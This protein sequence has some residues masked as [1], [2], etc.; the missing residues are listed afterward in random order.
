[1][2][3]SHSILTLAL[4]ASSAYAR[5]LT[6]AEKLSDLHQLVAI[7]KSG[8]GPLEYKKE[9]IGLDVDQLSAKYSSIVQDTRSNADF[10]RSLI[11]FVAEFQ[12]SHFSSW[13]PTPV[14][15]T[16]PFTT[17]LVAGKVVIDT[18][19]R[20]KLSESTFPFQRG[21]EIVSMNGQSAADL[22]TE[23]SAYIGMGFQGS[24][25]RR[26]AMS[27][28]IRPGK[29]FPIP[30]GAVALIIRRG[31]S[32]VT[33]PAA[34]TWEIQGEDAEPLATTSSLREFG[35]TVRPAVRDF[36]RIS[37]DFLW[38]DYEKYRTERSFRCSGDSRIT[39]PEGAVYIMKT[40]F[41]AYYYPTPKGN[42]GYLRIP[43]YYPEN[44]NTGEPEFEL[45]FKQYEYAVAELERN[46]VGLIIDQ[47][48]NCGGSVDYL[49]QIASLFMGPYEPMQFRLLANKREF[50]AFQDWVNNA[51][52]HTMEKEG[53]KR[54]MELLKTTWL[55][56][57]FM[58]PKTALNGLPTI[59]PHGTRYTKPIVMLIDE[60]SGSGGDAFPALLQGNGRATLLG[61]RTMGAGGHVED[62]EPLHFSQLQTRMTKSLFFRPDGVP[63]E[64]NGAEPNIP[65][66]ITWEDFTYG[67]QA[68]REFYTAELLKLIP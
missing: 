57:E 23:L 65:Y 63:V 9:K 14:T 54:T 44:E 56:G 52:D 29:T 62:Q 55:A 11:R 30:Q 39:P 66:A 5:P 26:A 27:F 36:D 51:P 22:L 20:K 15:A 59:A 7:V 34:L 21:D 33:Q 32:S 2:K 8:Y 41:V 17:D 40:P 43:H 25:A 64:N 37:T 1:M 45:R 42:V 67:Y 18:I 12:D 49:H 13:I 46:T 61:T 6:N 58:T 10:Y 48:H 3:F 68:Y 19:D 38:S 31:T 16:L 53:V 4:A 24:T 35:H 60:M 50:L 47:D 28:T